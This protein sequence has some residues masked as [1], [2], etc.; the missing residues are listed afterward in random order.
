MDFPLEQVN[1]VNTIIL[2]KR[3]AQNGVNY[4]EQKLI[5]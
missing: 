3:L 5:K 2:G 1:D 4:I